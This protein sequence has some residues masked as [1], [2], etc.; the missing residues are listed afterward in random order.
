VRPQ[1]K[2]LPYPA[3]VV[4]MLLIPAALTVALE[5]T[6]AMLLYSD[7]ADLIRDAAIAA[8]GA[9]ITLYWGR[10]RSQSHLPALAEAR[11]AALQARIR[12]HFLFNSLNAVLGLIRTDAKRAEHMLEDLADLFRVLM[13][14]HHE[15]VALQE[16]LA[17]C[18]QYL[19]IESLRLGERLKIDIEVD[20]RAGSAQVP[21]LLLQPLIEN[22]V[23]HGIEPVLEPGTVEVRI[24]RRGHVIEIRISNPWH[25]AMPGRGHQIGL[26]NVRQRLELLHD[27]E[28]RLETKVVAGRFEVVM[29]LPYI[30]QPGFEDA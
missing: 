25:G 3:Q 13:R 17:L 4:L 23:L 28:A 10:L 21:L 8:L 9:G 19:A 6:L 1:A 5:K 14:D 29:I 7:T 30:K 26:S 24:I 16:E 2:R 11:V 18:R 27:L 12:P 15:R 22:S 20:P